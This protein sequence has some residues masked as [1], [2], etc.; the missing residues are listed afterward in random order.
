M[1]DKLMWRVVCELIDVREILFA[2]RWMGA[3]LSAMN[4]LLYRRPEGRDTVRQRRRDGKR[5]LNR[6]GHLRRVH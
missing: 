6:N 3:C 4:W 1:A 2:D 5:R